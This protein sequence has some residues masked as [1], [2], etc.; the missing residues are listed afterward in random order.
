MSTTTGQPAVIDA[1]MRSLRKASLKFWIAIAVLGTIVAIG[2][3]A[4]IVQLQNGMGVAGY[5]D[6]SFW[7][8]YIANVVTFIGFSYGGAVVSAIL[9]LTG[10]AWRGPLSRMAEGMALVTVLIGAAFIFPHLGRPSRLLNMITHANPRSPVFW[11]MVAI[12][13]YPF[14]TLIF[15]LLPLIPDLAILRNA[16][17]DELGRFRRRLYRLISKGWMGSPSQRETLRK[18][19]IIMSIL[20]IPL[21]VSVHSVLSWAFS[22]VSRP[23]WHESIWAPYFVIAALYSG[24]ALAILVI[25]GFRRGYHL[26]AQINAHHFVRLG[27]IMATLGAIYAYLTFADLLPSAYVGERGPVAIIY[28]MLTGK[29]AAWFWLFIVAGVAVPIILV[30]LPWTRNTW[31]MVLA[32]VLVVFAMWIKRMLMI[33]ETS[34]YDRLSMSFGGFFHFTWVSIAVT[35]AGTAAIPLLL[36]LLF[37]AVPLLA[38]DE[39]QELSGEPQTLEHADDAPPRVFS[40]QKAGVVAGLLLM[41][42][43]VSMGIGQAQPAS[44]ADVAPAPANVVVSAVATGPNVDVTATVTAAGKPAANVPVS[45][46]ASTPMFAPGDNR[47][48]LGQVTTDPSGVAKIS[49]VAAEKGPLTFYADYYFN[50]EENPASGNTQVEISNALSPYVATDKTRPLDANGRALVKILFTAVIAVFIIVIVQ[51]LRVRRSLRVSA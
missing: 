43:L 36:M 39:I 23:G 47:I 44:A 51:A 21:A 40:G 48:T 32:S 38:I 2:I 11:D 18:A 22:L 8:V 33:V 42:G 35:L 12:I 9:L 19:S 6:R 17:S 34:G 31:G 29:A 25:A 20:I 10:A 4:W 41:I 27:Y 50:V 30:A 14:A 46:Y 13:T 45:F 5:T 49:Y 3:A 37:R 1:S 16:H 7:A 26:E 15:F 24:V 28:A